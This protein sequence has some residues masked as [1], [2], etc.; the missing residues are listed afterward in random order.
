MRRAP[1]DLQRFAPL[2][3]RSF[4]VMPDG[5]IKV[6]P[7]KRHIMPYWLVTEPEEITVPA[8][9]EMCP[10]VV[11]GGNVAQPIPLPID[12]KG[13]FEVCY[14]AFAAKFAAGPQAGQ[15]TDQFMVVIFD[16]QY[17]PLLMNREI[18]ARTLGGGFGS[19]PSG[20]GWG[21]AFASA[22]GRPLVWP[23]TFFMEP[24]Q[25]GRCLFM[26]FRN[27]NT[28]PIKIRWTF[29]GVRYY[30]LQAY[31]EA[32][33]EKA[34]VVGRERFTFPYFYTTDTNVRL[35]ADAGAEYDIRVTDEAD[36][37]IFKMTHFSDAEFLWRIQE[38]AG[39]RFLDSAGQS[40]TGGPHGVHSSF[41]WGDAEFPFI[42]FETMYYER[43]FKIMLALANTL[44]TEPNR[45][46]AT[47]I[48][49]KIEHKGGMR[50]L[51]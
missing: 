43:N 9:T 50:C 18:H 21:T 25:G 20:A 35:E 39:K 24:T 29:H 49:R 19:A 10:G 17:R 28:Q 31:K 27:L 7:A 4:I 41:G 11:R 22:G 34:K 46:F 36:L 42:T 51:A 37:E 44:S 47:L 26:G 15:P 3:G 40:A 32:L 2:P 8:A 30:H 5:T 1:A 38:K 13:P 14:S 23:E 33:A 12:D 48:S 45:I 16:P 6:D